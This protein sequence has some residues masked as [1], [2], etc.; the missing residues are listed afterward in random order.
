MKKSSAVRSIG[1]YV[2]YITNAHIPSIKCGPFDYHGFKKHE[3]C[4]TK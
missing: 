1:Y 3:V 2:V 4:L